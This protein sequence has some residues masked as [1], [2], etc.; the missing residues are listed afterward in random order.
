MGATLSKE[1]RLCGKTAISSLVAEGRWGSALHI[2]YCYRT[3]R[4]AEPTDSAPAPVRI[5]V[6]VPKKF[7]KRAVKRNLL[8]RR[9]REAY[10]LNKSLLQPE[11][12]VD[13]LFSYSSKE[14]VDFET[15]QNEVKTILSRIGAAL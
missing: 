1:E 11:R 5:M 9:I 4:E 7:F 13:V 3:R 14:I 10:R 15:I 2:R 12:G 8:K 6:S